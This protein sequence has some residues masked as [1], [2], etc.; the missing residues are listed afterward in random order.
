MGRPEPPSNPNPDPADG[1]TPDPTPDRPPTPRPAREL[2]SRIEP[3]SEPRVERVP[4][5]PAQG[6]TVPF[7]GSPEARGEFRGYTRP[8]ETSSKATISLILS[9][10]G[11]FI[12]PIILSVIAIIFGWVALSDIDRN[13]ALG[14]KGL[15][16]A[17][18]VIGI[19]GIIIGVIGVI[20]AASYNWLIVYLY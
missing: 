14:G 9:I 6:P 16:V 4:E 11:I 8:G 12:I 5:G 7:P 3:D 2:G 10:V 13:P 17:G 19:I 18:I 20:V 1:P 15:A